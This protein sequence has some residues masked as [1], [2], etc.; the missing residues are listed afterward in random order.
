MFNLDL[1]GPYVV[2]NDPDEEK[3]EF[4][5]KEIIPEEQAAANTKTTALLSYQMVFEDAWA[6]NL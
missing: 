6:G 4:G 3:A 5:R 1:S 2:L